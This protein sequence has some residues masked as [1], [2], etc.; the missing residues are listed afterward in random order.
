[1]LEEVPLA[2]LSFISHQSTAATAVE[3]ES[4]LSS[5]ELRGR[6]A[7]HEEDAT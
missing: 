2:G 6:F 7:V 5:E 4:A 3:V 1:M